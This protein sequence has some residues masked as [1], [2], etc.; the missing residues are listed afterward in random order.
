MSFE[1]TGAQLLPGPCRSSRGQGLCRCPCPGGAQPEGKCLCQHRV[2]LEA[3]EG[4][5]SPFRESP[6][7]FRDGPSDGQHGLFSVVSLALEQEA[8]V[9]TCFSHPA[10][11]ASHQLVSQLTLS[12]STPY[13]SP[14]CWF[15]L[16]SFVP[17]CLVNH[18]QSQRAGKMHLGAPWKAEVWE[19]IAGGVCGGPA[20]SMVYVPASWV[21]RPGRMP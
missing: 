20:T 6:G 12:W 5:A 4:S 16:F 19:G 17:L 9:P 3:Q 1:V 18:R 2:C 14:A 10:H 15:I 7:C 8:C 21:P 13:T 11:P